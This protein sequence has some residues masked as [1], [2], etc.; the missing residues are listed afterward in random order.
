M[1]KYLTYTARSKLRHLI[2]S[3][4]VALAVKIRINN[5]NIQIEFLDRNYKDK[6]VVICENPLVL[7]DTETLKS[8][9]NFSIDFDYQTDTFK[10]KV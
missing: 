10:I 1:N 7:T 9:E 8:L 3:D 2:I 6:D 4:D 5:K